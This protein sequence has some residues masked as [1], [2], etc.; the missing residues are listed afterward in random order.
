[1]IKV[2]TKFSLQNLKLTFF[3]IFACT[4]PSVSCGDPNFNSDVAVDPFSSTIVGSEL[5]YQCQSGLLPEGRMSSVCGGDGRWN[6]DPAT[7]MCEGKTHSTLVH[8]LKLHCLAF[9]SV[10]CGVPRPPQNG[11]IVNYTST[12]EGS[13]LLYQCNP[14]FDPMGE[15]T[16]VCAANGSWSPDPADLTCKG[17]SMCS[18]NEHNQSLFVRMHLYFHKSKVLG[19]GP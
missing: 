15:M 16:A 13:A 5:F 11:T 7:L 3:V 9:S 6:P 14:G 18:G 8:K 19:L 2:L 17:T 10:Y 4:H 12:V 1:M